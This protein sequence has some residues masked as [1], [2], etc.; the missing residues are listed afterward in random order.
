V[1]RADVLLARARLLTRRDDDRAAFRTVR[2]A[3]FRAAM[4]HLFFLIVY[5]CSI[6]LFHYLKLLIVCLFFVCFHLIKRV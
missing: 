1:R 3:T 2:F 5:L 4:F 6:I